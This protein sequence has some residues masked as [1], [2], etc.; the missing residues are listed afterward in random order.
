MF[1]RYDFLSREVLGL[2]TFELGFTLSWGKKVFEG[3]ADG[4]VVWHLRLSRL[5]DPWPG[6]SEARR[7]GDSRARAD[8]LD[9]DLP[10]PPLPNSGTWGLSFGQPLCCGLLA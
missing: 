1:P 4:S 9:W 8:G 6:G 2:T 10:A 5:S 7:G 3:Q